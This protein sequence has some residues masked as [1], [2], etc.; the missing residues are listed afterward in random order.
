[1][2][3]VLT[4]GTVGPMM[5]LSGPRAAGAW[6]SDRVLPILALVVLVLVLGVALAS[7][8]PL[9][10]RRTLSG[11]A[12][13]VG[14][15]SLA[16]L[17]LIRGWH[18][19]GRRRSAW[20]LLVLAGL[21]A[22]T[23][24]VSLVFRDSLHRSAATTLPEV[25]L[26]VAFLLGI[27]GALTFPGER[28]HGVRLLR[29]ALDGL[30]IGGSVLFVISETLFPEVLRTEPAAA[31]AQLVTVASAVVEVMVATAMALLAWRGGS[32]P[33]QTLFL[34]G[35]AFGLFAASDFAAAVIGAR[36]PF[37]LGTPVDL[38]WLGGYALMF[39]AIRRSGVQTPPPDVDNRLSPVVGTALIFGI[40]LVAAGV[41]VWES[42]NR[43]SSASIVVGL[44]V[45]VAVAARQV[46]LIVDNERLQR[47]LESRVARRTNTLRAISQQI[48]L[49]IDSVGEGIYG[50]DAQGMVTFVNP[51]AARL[52]DYNAKDLIGQNAHATFHVPRLD[53]A[54]PPCHVDEAINRQVVAQHDECTYLRA[55][56]HQI[57]VE[58]T[59]TPLGQD[60]VVRGAVVVFRDITHRRAVDQM[61]SEFVAMVSHELRTPLTSIRGSLGLLAGGALGRLDPGATRMVELALDSTD[62]LSRLV[63]DI[64]DT[65]RIESGA[66]PMSLGVHVAPDLV[67]SAVDQVQLIATAEEVEV[68]VG[69]VEGW[70]RADGD[71]VVQVLLNLL[72]NAIKFSPPGQRVDVAARVR[73]SAVEF[74]VSDLGRGVPADKLDLIFARFQQVDTSDGRGGVG[75]GLSISRSLVERMGGRI[76]AE[77]NPGGGTTFRFVL[78]GGEL[79]VQ[80][81]VEAA[82][83]EGGWPAGDSRPLRASS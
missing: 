41:G 83:A 29:M 46:L 43:L 34:A 37:S 12:L 77:P 56:G 62:R 63:D 23:S 8:L 60:G 67:A 54:A 42:R 24:N 51:A 10:A 53:P 40:F 55:D 66:L 81:R 32:S 13:A 65:E 33:R 9:S 14:G 71:R 20:G 31:P 64:L 68:H 16:G 45:L 35:L 61:K 49:L 69:D 80:P 44:I 3:R 79:A 21:T 50:V 36:A 76:W 28:W 59:A 70:V 58:V 17:C 25:M 5:G 27:A 39:L 74:S 15:L 82:D 22:A 78:P 26:S 19:S 4:G 48:T 57:P 75:L 52:L 73:R 47:S 7:D 30:I 1:M 72:S 6:R 38:G 18:A 2:V 11:L